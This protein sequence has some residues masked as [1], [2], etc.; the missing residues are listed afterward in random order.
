[1]PELKEACGIFGIYNNPKAAMIT[2]MGLFA[3]QHRGEESAGM[4]G[5]HVP[6]VVE[7]EVEHSDRDGG[8]LPVYLRRAAI[9]GRPQVHRSDLAVL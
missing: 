3:L 2:V 7:E 4:A 8:G 9:Q 1:M 5:G 6:S